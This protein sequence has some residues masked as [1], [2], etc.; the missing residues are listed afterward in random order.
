MFSC[1]IILLF[2]YEKLEFEIAQEKVIEQ[3]EWL[4]QASPSDDF[5]KAKN[6]KDYRFIGLFGITH[7]IPVVDTTLFWITIHS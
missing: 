4:L 5:E 3:M 2:G 7:I 1:I 6:K